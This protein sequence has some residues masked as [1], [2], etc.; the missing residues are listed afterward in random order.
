M[1]LICNVKGQ[2]CGTKRSVG[3]LSMFGKMFVELF[4]DRV[5]ESTITEIGEEHCDSRND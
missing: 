3:L 5:V 2:K 4:L 1:L